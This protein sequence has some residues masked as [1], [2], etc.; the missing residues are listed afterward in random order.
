VPNAGVRLAA[1]DRVLIY[2][3]DTGPSPDVVELA[4]LF[5]LAAEA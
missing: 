2:T 4:S 3:G 5:Q 1:G